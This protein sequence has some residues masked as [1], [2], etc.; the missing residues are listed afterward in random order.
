M[1]PI[2]DRR[3]LLVSRD[4]AR[5]SYAQMPPEG[6]TVADLVGWLEDD[7]YGRMVEVDAA[8]A[9][10]IEEALVE[11]GVEFRKTVR[12]RR[13]PRSAAVIAAR[14]RADNER[15]KAKREHDERLRAERFRRT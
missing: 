2:D 11:V 5:E 14:N 8:D 9:D 1:E 6:Y 13:A 3:I 4:P 12:F 15:H 7:D 10:A